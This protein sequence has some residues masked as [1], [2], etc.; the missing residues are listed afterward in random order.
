MANSTK[1]HVLIVGVAGRTG[2]PIA[3]SLLESGHFS[4]TG[5]V[6]PESLDKPIIK[7]LQ[8]LGVSIVPL[9]WQNASPEELQALFTGV[10]TVL[11]ACH[12]AAIADQAKLVDAA[13]ASGVK[14]FV[15]SDWSPI[16]PRGAMKLEDMKHSFHD[17]LFDS[18]IPYTLIAL[19][20]WY[21]GIFPPLPP[22]EPPT[23]E[24]KLLADKVYHS[25]GKGKVKNTVVNRKNAGN[26]VARVVADP[27]TIG[28][29]VLVNEDEVSLDEVW[30]L[31][32]K[33]APQ[34]APLR[35][36]VS[37]E[38]VE[39]IIREG[40]SAIGTFDFTNLKFIHAL[41]LEAMRN[42]YINGH[43][44]EASAKADGWLVARERY[45]DVQLQTAA[46]WARERY[47]GFS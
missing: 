5:V 3:R 11:S 19:G 10:D 41:F 40:T 16:A 24:L 17:Y 32:T 34:L 7:E 14:R 9:D 12:P 45:P 22:Y 29:K 46:D 23:A 6:R 27:E 31:A 47:A 26:L 37:D 44:S 18:G 38:D 21:D 42:L 25:F 30:A 39:R 43:N 1:N 35:V 33:Y 8:S 15:P 2:E 13:K 20:T 28:K 4:V 36:P